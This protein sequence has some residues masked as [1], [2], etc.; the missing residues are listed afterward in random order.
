MKDN[1][2]LK[3]FAYLK[4]YKKESILGPLFKLLEALFELFIPLVVA[5]IIDKGIGEENIGIIIPMFIVMVILGLIGLI[6][7]VTAQY[8]SAKAAVGFS[9][10]IR[11]SLFNKLQSLSYSEIDDL[12]TSKMITV[13]TNDVNQVQNG[14]NLTLRLLLRSP[15]IVFGSMIMAL[16]ISPKSALIF[17]GIICCLSIIVFFIMLITMPMYKKVQE[18]VDVVLRKTRENLSGVRVIRAFSREKEEVEEF[19]TMN[20]ALNKKQNFVG[21]IS[22]LM[23]PLTYSIINIGIIILLQFGAIRV[24]EGLLTQGEV[25]AL[26][27]Y[28]SQILVELIKFANLIITLSKSI[29]CGKRISNILEMESS[30]DHLPEDIKKTSS[31]IEFN[32]VCLEYKKSKADS[33]TN[34]TFKVNKGETIGIIGG[35]GS[36]KTSLINLLPHFYDST[37]G[38]VLINGKDVKSYNDYALRNMIGIVPQKAVLFKGTIRSNLLWGNEN[39]TDEE[40]ME[41]VMLSESLDVVNKKEN[42]LDE[43]VEQNGRNYSG[44]QKQRL[45]IARALVKKPEILIFDDSSSA[46]DYQTDANLRK[47]LQNLDYNPTIFIVSQRTSS[48]K[49]ADKIIVLEDGLMV[50]MGKHEE[51]LLSCDV[52][53]EIHYSQYKKE[54][55]NEKKYDF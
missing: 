55:K 31:F 41:A 50:G 17:I 13:I 29:A 40:L 42:K 10:N 51:L 28:M 4:E 25:I 11:S 46:L 35:T 9:K 43:I 19:D 37:E 18:N 20:N 44:G 34:I 8:F 24:N 15:F 30:L 6:C 14:V 53:K 54:N 48:I 33:L 32:N 36:G 22:G 1:K 5:A 23:N 49:H 12:G 7:S 2:I 16:F 21:M 39:A 3:L 47:N 45:T 38:N 26:Y 52:Y 27:N